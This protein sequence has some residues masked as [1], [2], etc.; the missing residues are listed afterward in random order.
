MKSKQQGRCTHDHTIHQKISQLARYGKKPGAF[1]GGYRKLYY[2]GDHCDT[3]RKKDS[4][5]CQWGVVHSGSI[6]H[7][8]SP[9]PRPGRSIWRSTVI[10]PASEMISLS[11]Y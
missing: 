4:I 1:S 11:G 8:C 10:A 7:R 5:S 2:V 9:A 3:K 6:K